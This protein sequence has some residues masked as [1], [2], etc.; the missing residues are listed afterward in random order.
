MQSFVQFFQ[1]LTSFSETDTDSGKTINS[2][3]EFDSLVIEAND[4][5]Q[6]N[7]TFYGKK[8]INQPNV[9]ISGGELIGSQA[10]TGWTSEGAG[11]YSKVIAEPKWVYIEGQDAKLSETS[12]ININT[13]PA[14]NQIQVSAGDITTDPV[15][16]KM[17]SQVRDFAFSLEYTITAH[18]SG[19]LT[20][21][22][23][24]TDDFYSFSTSDR[25]RLFG[26]RAYITNDC[27]WAYESGTLY[28][29]LPSDP[30][31]FTIRAVDQDYGLNVTAAGFEMSGTTV[32]EYFRGGVEFNQNINVDN[33]VIRD[34]RQDGFNALDTADGARITN[35]QIFNCGTSGIFLT[36]SSNT[37]VTGNTVYNIGTKAT[38]GWLKEKQTNRGAVIGMGIIANIYN[39]NDIIS[40][41]W[42]IDEN[43]VYNT[44]YNGIH[45][46]Y[47]QDGFIRKN[48]VH[49]AMQV[50]EDGGGIY[51]F[52]FR[53]AFPELANNI[54]V[55][56]NLVYDI[57][58]GNT[59][60]GIYLDNRS[61]TV[62]ILRNTVQTPNALHT[63]YINRGTNVRT[64]EDNVLVGGTAQTFRHVYISDGVVPVAENVQFNRNILVSLNAADECIRTEG[65]IFAGV[66]GSDNNY[67]I[68]P[69]SNNV[70]YDNLSFAAWQAL[71]GTD[72]NS[73]AHTN[74]IV[75]PGDPDNDVLL[76]TN[77][78]S[79]TLNGTAPAGSYKD[80]DGNVV[81]N[82]SVQPWRSLVL[83]K[84]L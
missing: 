37:I 57:P 15:G 38:N 71:Y 73:T 13:L 67:F 25:I 29:K 84:D 9:S 66:G 2:Q 62:S 49:D 64:I 59:N 24:H 22:K 33:C 78:D 12:L 1:I 20:L 72:A 4:D 41:G 54:E 58:S 68:Q 74:Y 27:D 55:S 51:T 42:R 75:A 83:L 31:N 39:A 34:I 56:D 14:N 26:L 50:L 70:A 79:T 17:V 77:P 43:H 35:N 28:V 47:G 11:I 3:A 19:L 6:L 10:V 48:I 5:I 21:D 81:T 30:T 32:R 60:I 80:V 36:N 69:Y 46:S 8:E 63:V 16:A 61:G 45:S 76:I 82:Y 44:A 18:S 52:F 23:N 53:N 65:N 7:G 40:T